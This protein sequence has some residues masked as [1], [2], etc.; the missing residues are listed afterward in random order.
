[1][2]KLLSLILIAV[3]LSVIG[4]QPQGQQLDTS[5]KGAESGQEKK[6]KDQQSGNDMNGPSKAVTD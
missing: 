4:C 6:E 3:L 5:A 1:M 2:Q